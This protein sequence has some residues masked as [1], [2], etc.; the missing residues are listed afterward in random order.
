MEYGR[1]LPYRACVGVM[2]LN[3]AGQV[4]IGQR[5]EDII[6]QESDFRWQMPQGGIDPGEAPKAAAF[7]E[8]FEETGAKSAEIIGETVGWLQYDLPSASIG[9]ALKGKYRGQRMK[10]FA[11]R[12]TGEESEFNI[13]RINEVSPEFDAW[14]WAEVEELPQ[15]IVPFKREVYQAVIDEFAH[16]VIMKSL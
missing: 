1:N 7:R 14:R 4:W 15:L 8:L 3:A 10:W 16:I 5:L 9:S 13:S 2:L 11:M 6:G 12:F